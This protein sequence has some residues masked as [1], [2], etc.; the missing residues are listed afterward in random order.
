[1]DLRAVAAAAGMAAAAERQDL[2]TAEPAAADRVTTAELES[3]VEV[4]KA[5]QHPLQVTTR[6]QII[7]P[8]SESAERP[9]AAVALTAAM[10]ASSSA[11]NYQSNQFKSIRSES[12]KASRSDATCAKFCCKWIQHA[13]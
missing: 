1:M 2:A 12:A 8:A 3:R 6:T 4:R 5:D 11:T 13:C 9:T 10:A 7:S